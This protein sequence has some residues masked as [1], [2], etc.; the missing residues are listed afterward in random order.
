M[1]TLPR[2]PLLSLVIVWVTAIGSA[3]VL[4][5]HRSGPP[6]AALASSWL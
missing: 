1:T 6:I 3:G 5:R 2:L 4:A